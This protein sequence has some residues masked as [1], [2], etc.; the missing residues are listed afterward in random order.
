MEEKPLTKIERELVLQYLIDGNVPVTITPLVQENK[1]D[2][3]SEEIKSLDSSVVP[4]AF[5]ADKVSVIKEGI[6]ILE[7][8]P[9]SILKS[10]DKQ[11]KV[12][13]YFNSV[14]LY[15]ITILKKINSGVALVIPENIY[16]IPD[17]SI[18]KKYDFTA[19]L[20]ISVSSE[21]A[22][23]FP[24]VPADG[25][26]LF[27][28]PVWSSIELENQQRAK[29]LLEEYVKEAKVKQ[30]SGNGL[31]LINIC[32]YMVL[33]KIEKVEAIKGRV[34]P[35]DILFVNHER[36]VFGFEKNEAFELSEGSEYPVEM[37]FTLKESPVAKRKI[38]VTCKVFNLYKNEDGSKFAADCS[39]TMIQEEDRRFL[40]EKATKTLF[41]RRG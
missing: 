27:A 38:F 13:F 17:V 5:K 22:T 3:N 19:L 39:Y 6:I 10:I 2:D 41:V 26:E 15:F 18:E 32:R 12:E 30:K 28:R 25:F 1:T 20:V 36:I 24:C 29:K 21:G 23:K 37:S 35:F 11:V 40:Y 7:D 4:V 34:K 9:E 33:P 16:R 8:E 31:Q 14:G